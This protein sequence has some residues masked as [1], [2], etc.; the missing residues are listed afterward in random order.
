METLKTYFTLFAN[1]IKENA[2]TVMLIFIVL[3]M[4][5]KFGIG[6]LLA[7]ALIG[8]AIHALYTRF[9]K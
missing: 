4:F 9:G 6:F 2:G 5:I 8:F 7:C 3:N 1:D